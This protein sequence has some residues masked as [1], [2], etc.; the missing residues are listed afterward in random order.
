MCKTDD[1]DD[2]EKKPFRPIAGHYADLTA[3]GITEA[4]C[5]KCEESTNKGSCGTAG[6]TSS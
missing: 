1:D 2:E 6:S 4:T 3:R 5:K